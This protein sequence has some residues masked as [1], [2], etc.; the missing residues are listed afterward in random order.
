VFQKRIRD[1]ATED[2]QTLIS[3][4]W[5]ESFD[6]EFKSEIP[7]DSAERDRWI[8]HGDRVERAGGAKILREVVAFANA[9]GGTLVLGI[10]ETEDDPKRAAKLNPIP[11]CI[12]LAERFEAVMR[13]SIEPRLAFVECSGVPLSDDGSGV[14]IIRAQASKLGPHWVAGTRDAAIRRGAHSV[15]MTMSEIQDLTLKLA[16]DADAI[17]REFDRRTEFFGRRFSNQRGELESRYQARLV[18]TTLVARAIGL[19]IAAIPLS[20]ITVPDVVNDTSLRLDPAALQKV[21][22]LG[23]NKVEL[24]FFV[25]GAGWRPILRGIRLDQTTTDAVH[26]RELAENG[27]IDFAWINATNAASENDVKAFPLD[28]VLWSVAFVLTWIELL[29]M[30]CSFPDLPFALSLD[31]RCADDSHIPALSS[32]PHSYRYRDG[33]PQEVKLPVYRAA[34]RVEFQSLLARVAHDFFNAGGATFEAPIE[35]DFATTIAG[36]NI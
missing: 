28:Q 20:P 36:L 27:A 4:Q 16:R 17:E 15:S 23:A 6:L 26:Y 18:G 22:K 11:R 31:L 30:R 5:P 21:G 33:F 10:E 14:V 29:R 32:H 3:E 19:H 1:L 24:P 9:H 25:F 12:E 35:F 34:D 13:D 2:I 7:T 8:M